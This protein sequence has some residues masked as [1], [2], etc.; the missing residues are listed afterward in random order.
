MTIAL[1]AEL[2]AHQR[3]IGATSCDL[4]KARSTERRCEPVIKREGQTVGGSVD[5]ASV[6]H[7][8]AV[9]A[10]PIDSAREKHRRDP[11]PAAASLGHKQ[12]MPQTRG[13]SARLFSV[14]H[15]LDARA[16]V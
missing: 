7:P 3:P 9:L 5:R 11:L 12:E 8:C 1:I 16:K 13:S 2:E 6:E 15:R 4:V 10:G 14:E